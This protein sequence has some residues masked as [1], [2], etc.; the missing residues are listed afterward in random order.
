MQLQNITLYNFIY[1]NAQRELFAK[2]LSLSNT[3]DLM[4]QT[5]THT[6]RR[7]LAHRRIKSHQLY[8]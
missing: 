5:H 4:E 2:N 1:S 6:H 3:A 7:K 8:S